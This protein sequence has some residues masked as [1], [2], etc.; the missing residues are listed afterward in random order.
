MSRLILLLALMAA[1]HTATGEGYPERGRSMIISTGGIVA[2]EHPLASQAAAQILANGGNAVD[3]AITANACMGVL[4]PMQCGMGGDLFAIIYEAKSGEIHGLNASGWSAAAL[5]AESL[6]KQGQSIMPTN[7]PHV[8]TVPGCVSGWEHLQKK[9]ARKKLS[10]LLA[11]AITLAENGAPVPEIIGGYWRSEEKKLRKETSTAAVFLPNDRAPAVGEV[12]KNPDMAWSLRQVARGGARAFYNGPVSQR[13]V[14]YLHAKGSLITA[15]DFSEFS[16]EWVTPIHTSYRGW[17]VYEIPPNGQGIAAL[18]MLNIMENFPL[19]DWGHNSSNALHSMI[20][21]KKLAYADMLKYVGDQR[22]SKVPAPGM[23]S[24]KHARNRG[25]LIDAAKANCN[26]EGSPSF[27]PGPDTTYLCVVDKEG[28]M[29]S[30]IQSIYHSFGSGLVAPGTGFAL[31]DRGALFTLEANHPNVLAGRKRPVHTIIPAFMEK[32]ETR[33]AFGIMGGWNQSQAHAQFVA[34]VVDYG[35][36]IQ[37]A[38]EAPRFTKGTFE[39]CDVKIEG[40]VSAGIL[41]D[42]KKRGHIVTVTEP[43]HS[44]MGCGQAVLRNFTSKVNFGA[45][46]P[47]K[48]GAAIPEPLR[49]GKR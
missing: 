45:S 16:A 31:H 30:L 15:E 39:G 25:K 42:L 44:D 49:A 38:L 24:K 1:I 12:F 20:E 21:A 32:G 43:L 18:S 47:R 7:G 41:E 27:D 19:H 26:V 4:S 13:L 35:M 28:N 36:N 34:N 22:F 14:D 3:A 37:Q 9:F 29:V 11:P 23:L 8:V 2:T 33:I 10:E 5:N 6:R 48:D 17:T 46:D 40:R